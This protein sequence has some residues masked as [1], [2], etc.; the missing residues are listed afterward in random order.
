MVSIELSEH[1]QILTREYLLKTQTTSETQ[2]E[3]D[4]FF[5]LIS[6]SLKIKVQNELYK[7]VLQINVVI[8][9]ILL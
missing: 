9:K 1:E 3:M 5:D 4:K 8:N 7:E 2:T 6:P